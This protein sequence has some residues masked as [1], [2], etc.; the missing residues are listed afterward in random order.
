VL[1]KFLLSYFECCQ[2]RLNILI[3]DCHLI[4]ITK[5]KRK[6]LIKMVIVHKNI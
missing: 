1:Q 4:N 2:I 5:L 3:D 6:T